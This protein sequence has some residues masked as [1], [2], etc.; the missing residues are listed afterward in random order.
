MKSAVYIANRDGRQDGETA[1]V[2]SL[3]RNIVVISTGEGR[4][5]DNNGAKALREQERVHRAIQRNVI[6]IR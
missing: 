3:V 4:P 1:A 2:V 5:A 6:A